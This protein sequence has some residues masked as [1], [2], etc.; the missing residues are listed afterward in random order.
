MY[1]ASHII[2]QNFHSL[3]NNTSDET[4]QTYVL[5]AVNQPIRCLF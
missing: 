3:T 5:S 1:E 2:N 4:H